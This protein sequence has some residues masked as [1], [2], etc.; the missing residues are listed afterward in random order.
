MMKG[1]KIILVN[2][3]GEILLNHRDK[4]PNIANPDKWS[5]FGGGVEKGES[6]D[7][8]IVREVKEELGFELENFSFFR[9]YK[10]DDELERYVFIGFIDKELSELELGEGDDMGYFSIQDAMKL[11]LSPQTRIYLSD[12]FSK[13]LLE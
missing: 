4:N 11:D 3:N 8:A 12:Y 7:A 6:V 13:K 9:K 2:S 5:L 10:F 1:A